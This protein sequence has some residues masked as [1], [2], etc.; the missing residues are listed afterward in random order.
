M[1]KFSEGVI[2]LARVVNDTVLMIFRG[3]AYSLPVIALMG[4]DIQC[5]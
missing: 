5:E 3:C 1:E 4:T 2:Y